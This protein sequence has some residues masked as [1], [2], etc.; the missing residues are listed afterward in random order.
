MQIV[1]CAN[2]PST[3]QQMQQPQPFPL[4]RNWAPN[5]EANNIHRSPPMQPAHGVQKPTEHQIP[6]LENNWNVGQKNNSSQEEKNLPDQNQD[7][8]N[9]VS[10]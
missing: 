9:T 8:N 10:C 1:G 2:L 6:T 5:T 7:G 4:G 3:S